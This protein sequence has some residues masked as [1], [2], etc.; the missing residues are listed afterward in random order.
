M[1]SRSSKS[2]IGDLRKNK[3]KLQAPKV[4]PYIQAIKEET[5]DP[6]LGSLK[7]VV[8]KKVTGEPYL[9]QRRKKERRVGRA[10]INY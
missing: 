9:G 5:M 3:S 1:R 8:D 6:H 7:R 2:K 4:A 10:I